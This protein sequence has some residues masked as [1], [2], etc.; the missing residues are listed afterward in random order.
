MTATGRVCPS[1][2]LGQSRNPGSP[3]PSSGPLGVKGV[4]V[5]SLHP[6]PRDLESPPSSPTTPLLHL[7]RPRRTVSP[8]LNGYPSPGVTEARVYPL[9]PGPSRPASTSFHPNDPHT[10]PV[11]SSV[12]RPSPLRGV[13]RWVSVRPNVSD[14]RE[15]TGSSPR[16][17]T[18][19]PTPDDPGFP[20]PSPLR[21]GVIRGARR[22]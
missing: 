11:R 22:E 18:P 6:L 4:D 16:L 3:F 10:P 12:R 9:T 19:V 21:D 15:T 7:H 8:Y 17:P 2:S 1:P 14:S 13:D 20:S 5:F